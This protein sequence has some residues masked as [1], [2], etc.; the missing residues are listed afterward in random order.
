MFNRFIAVAALLLCAVLP[1]SAYASPVT[2]TFDFKDAS[3]TD[4]AN[5]SF[6]FDS[7]LDGS[8]LS[9]ASL[10]AFTFHFPVSGASYD[11]AFVN[12]GGFQSPFLNFEF[13]SSID[14]FVFN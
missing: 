3:A 8:V 11:L 6:T 4:L 2:I 13:D 9:Y 7:S 1:V 10:S 5:G 12:S 14:A